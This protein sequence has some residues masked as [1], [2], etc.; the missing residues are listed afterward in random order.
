MWSKRML[1][2]CLLAGSEAT[3]SLSERSWLEEYQ[4]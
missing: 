2:T 1:G 3:T 4:L